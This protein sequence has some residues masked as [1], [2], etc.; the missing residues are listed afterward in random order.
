[1]HVAPPGERT[2]TGRA[3]RW[4]NPGFVAIRR[5]DTEKLNGANFKD[6]LARGFHHPLTKFSEQLTVRVF[7]AYVCK[8]LR[9]KAET[10]GA[11]L[12]IFAY[13]R[14]GEVGYFQDLYIP[15]NGRPLQIS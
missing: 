1:M 14:H 9:L 7:P 15:P 8:A 10:S 2:R 12:E 5:V 4:K 3:G 11:V 13:D 6:L